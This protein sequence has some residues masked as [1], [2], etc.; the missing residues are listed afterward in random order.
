MGC[1]PVHCGC[2][3]AVLPHA[4]SR[5]VFTAGARNPQPSTQ[6][7][8]DELSKKRKMLL[9]ATL[10]AARGGTVRA[11]SL[12]LGTTPPGPLTLA[13]HYLISPY[14]S[15]VVTLS[16]S[17]SQ[18]TPDPA[19]TAPP[20]GT[21][22]LSHYQPPL[23]PSAPLRHQP[24]SQHQLPCLPPSP[25]LP[26]TCSVEADAVR[27]P[28]VCCAQCTVHSPREVACGSTPGAQ[29][30]TGAHPKKLTACEHEQ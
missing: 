26:P 27:T 15:R 20:S 4:T 12:P 28:H 24:P 16:P 5:I 8:E 19:H 25:S 3:P 18:E 29:P 14:P 11:I 9:K 6:K 7:Q 17:A 10:G 22:Q 13:I 23:P 21:L 1:A 2:A 30:Q